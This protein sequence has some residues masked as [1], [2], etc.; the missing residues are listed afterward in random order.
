MYKYIYKCIYIHMYIN[1]IYIST[2]I[3]V[4]TC[5]YTCTFKG[6]YN[7]LIQMLI[8]TLIPILMHIQL[9]WHTHT[10]IHCICT[11]KKYRCVP[12]I[13]IMLSPHFA[14]VTYDTFDTHHIIHEIH[15]HT[16]VCMKV[17]VRVRFNSCHTS[18]A[19]YMLLALLFW[20]YNGGFHYTAPCHSIPWKHL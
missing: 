16:H 15:I 8:Q 14:F 1:D 10:D 17:C 4:N 3:H 18:S 5:K 11:C 9:H 12:H 20:M 2:Y 7:C 6:I 19:W 13:S